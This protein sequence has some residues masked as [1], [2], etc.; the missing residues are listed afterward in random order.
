MFED[1]AITLF[2]VVTLGGQHVDIA[3]VLIV[4]YQMRVFSQMR[5]LNDF[6]E[7]SKGEKR[8]WA[9]PTGST[10]LKSL[11]EIDNFI[12]DARKRFFAF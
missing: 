12:L 4:F 2:L 10:Q 6:S 9:N 1:F 11:Y 3:L 8:T 7:Q 5:F